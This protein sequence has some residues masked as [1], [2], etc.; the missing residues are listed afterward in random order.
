MSLAR[1]RLTNLFEYFKAVEHRRRP[2]IV[3]LKDQHW[4][5]SL[6]ELPS[7]KSIS[8]NSDRDLNEDGA[9]LRVSK[10]KLTS[11]PV[12]S[13]ELAPWLLGG[14]E[15]PSSEDPKVKLT[16]SI[17]NDGVLKEIRFDADP[18]RLSLYSTWLVQWR[19]WASEEGP[20]RLVDDFWSQLFSIH[21]DLQREGER[22][23]LMLGEG[24]LSFTVDER[25]IFHPIA[26]QSVSKFY[27]PVEKEF[28]LSD[29]DLG[30][31]LYSALFGSEEF[32]S[33][34]VKKWRN[35][36]E[37]QDLHP[38]DGGPLTHF[39]KGLIGSFSDG[40]F[41]D[42]LNK[43]RDGKLTIFRQPTLFV[44]RKE[45]GLAEFIDEVLQDITI[46]EDF[47]S[48][49]LGI[50]GINS[51]DHREIDSAENLKV[52]ANE[53]DNYLLTKP[54]N[55]EQLEIL[56][57]LTNRSDVLVQG[58]PGTGKTHTIANLIGN[59]LSEGKSVLIT[60][61][62]T[63]A[64]RVVREKVA[65]PL[66]ELCVSVLDNDK[67]SRT[68][69]ETAI[70]GLSE[71]LSGSSEEY[72]KD[73][74]QL[75]ERRTQILSAIRERRSEL[76]EAV[77]GEYMPIIF[78]G[79]QYFPTDVA[80]QL[81]AD[82]DA[83]SWIPGPLAHLVPC[84]L[85]DDEVIFLYR[86]GET[87]S[88]S[89]EAELSS[90]LPDINSIPS[91]TEFTSLVEEETRLES[92][93]SINFRSQL[94]T[95][96]YTEGDELEAI[97]EKVNDTGTK[98]K[99]VNNERWSLSIIEAG[100]SGG[101]RSAVWNLLCAQIEEVRTSAAETAESS[102]KYRPCL[103]D[104]S[105]LA[106]QLTVLSS[107]EGYVKV[108]GSISWLK[109]NL[110]SPSW[111]QHIKKWKVKDSQPK[112]QEEFSALRSCAELGVKR[113]DLVDSWGVMC[114]PLG[115]EALDGKD[116]PEEYA[117]QFVQLI[118]DLLDWHEKVW[119]PIQATLDSEGLKWSTLLLEAPA[120]NAPEHQTIR[121]LYLVEKILPSVIAAE[122][123]RRGLR[124]TKRKL[125][126]VVSY[127]LHIQQSRTRNSKLV[128]GL[129]DSLKI[130][131]TALYR[132][133]HSHLDSVLSKH[134]DLIKRI[135][136]LD[137]LMPIA[138]K[139]ALAL[140]NREI[141]F[142]SIKS[143]EEPLPSKAW[144]WTQLSQ[145]LDR[146]SSLSVDRILE[147]LRQLLTEL[148]TTTVKLV[149][150]RAWENL[151]VKVT[152]E[153]RRALMGWATT[154]KRIGSGTGRL[155]PQ[156]RKQAKQEMEAARG[157]VPI[158]IMPF[159]SITSSFHPVRD[160]FDV[161]IVDEASQEDVLGLASF[162]MAKKV[163]VVG[164]DEQVTPMD[165]GSQQEPLQNLISQ[166]I[167][168]LPSPRLFDTKTS[169][170]DRALISFGSV[171]RLR[172]HFRCVPEIIQF[173]NALCYDYTIQPL[174]EAASA[175]VGPALVVQ[176]VNGYAE[177]KT[178][179]VEAVEIVNIV[180][181]CLQLPEYNGL[182]FGIISMVGDE[183]AKLIDS[184]LRK[185][186][187]P[188]VY[189][190]RRILCGSPSQFQGDERDV[191]F[192]SF[193][194][195]EA[196]KLGPLTMRQDGAD[197]MW[198]KRFNVAASRAKDQLWVVV[199]LDHTTQLKPGDIRRRLI[200]HALDPSVLM[201]QL[202]SKTMKA[203]S[204]FEVE[205]INIL[206][207][208]G[209]QVTPQWQ[210]GAY[211]IDIVVEGSGKRLAVECDGDR[212]HYDKFEEDLARQ[213]L[214]ERLG[215]TFIRI[216]GSDF[217]RDKTADRSRAMSPVFAKLDQ[218]EI[219]PF[220]EEIQ[221][222]IGKLTSELVGKVR[223]L[224][225]RI[226]LAGDSHNDQTSESSDR[227]SD[228][229]T[230]PISE[231]HSGLQGFITV[232]P[233]PISNSQKQP[234]ANS[235]GQVPLFPVENG[236]KS[237]SSNSKGLAD[238]NQFEFGFVKGCRVSHEKF[239]PGT[240]TEL[241]VPHRTISILFEAPWGLKTLDLRRGLSLLS[242]GS[243]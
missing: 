45:T 20:I 84:P 111:T 92:D 171:V 128:A 33:F 119:S 52:H 2:R 211:R 214:L 8:F 113:K 35:S 132:E 4:S 75:Q 194:D 158:W 28:W 90:S 135:K 198:K 19:R 56:K 70:R 234:S 30:P 23:E 231:N 159:S 165:V 78:N 40:E 136:L 193:V 1:E 51:P 181:A 220:S 10:P 54:A 95:S 24:I 155:V 196:E 235:Q 96:L 236:D 103:H 226:R 203:E 192:L 176:R 185:H 107:I 147:S 172:E 104:G 184:E 108:N 239:G 215:W 62:S 139:W 179:R 199:S 74:N 57:R 38:L 207:A 22:L 110:L 187:D 69:R 120:T 109:L 212:W 175:Q 157:A 240:V 238:K 73:A 130:R 224:A 221:P 77:S 36:L 13:S 80:R 173:S 41:T 156:L 219:K 18:Q 121:I 61:H 182:T 210:V 222:V 94:W 6:N 3:N 174:R 191:V 141:N 37:D 123:K 87:I 43:V 112:T 86:S 137:C 180:R 223:S 150:S 217:Y 29:K 131:A 16:R 91:P 25:K 14:W 152:S 85:I 204:P 225:S 64:L 83:H 197:G 72:A 58:P 208:R 213:S 71:R 99:A 229:V 169:I 164:D 243:L 206:S 160:K 114:V 201:E 68:Q 183:Q 186:I 154:M 42:I 48:S 12:P 148:E 122:L 39:L 27:D 241:N 216:R 93:P 163:I 105:S 209:Y 59:F 166:W 47:P 153:Q 237:D 7:H 65:E 230:S 97:L 79:D 100:V 168:D 170:Y 167:S 98:L 34:D 126:D 144:A 205:V 89:D 233:R 140:K 67:E 134:A 88:A 66:R 218:M 116:A 49:L 53:H 60:S 117:S 145:E 26:L 106:E 102:F 118:R 5:Y 133:T 31:E 76:H 202:L 138:S 142:S 129:I 50:V 149:E 190:S 81:V 124:K 46:C 178:N 188:G 228:C 101:G 195:G 15:L 21:A 177:R 17:E 44:R 143:L 189:D 82:Q 55:A 151:L 227:V 242:K 162:Y 146:R 127:L 115:M 32:S 9:W 200:E 125:E 232:D 63:K 11:S 161:L